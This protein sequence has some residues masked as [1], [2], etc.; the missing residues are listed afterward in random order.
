LVWLL[1]TRLLRG[2]SLAG[3]LP[4]LLLSGFALVLLPGR[5]LFAGLIGLVLWHGD[6]P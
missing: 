5:L 3:I 2:L 4:A 6:A 1:L